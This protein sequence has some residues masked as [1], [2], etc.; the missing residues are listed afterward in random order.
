MTLLAENSGSDDGIKSDFSDQR[1][2]QALLVDVRPNWLL[3]KMG[4]SVRRTTTGHSPTTASHAGR[5][6]WGAWLHPSSL[7]IKGRYRA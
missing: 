4:T 1:Q 2:T 6:L 3:W 7:Y 5:S